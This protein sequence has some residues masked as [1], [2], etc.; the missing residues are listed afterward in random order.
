MMR[1]LDAMRLES[2]TTLRLFLSDREAERAELVQDGSAHPGVIGDLLH[3]LGDSLHEDADQ[4]ITAAVAASDLAEERLR[5]SAPTAP[6]AF[7]P[8]E[9]AAEPAAVEEKTSA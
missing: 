9:P 8:P 6:V 2:F 1:M 3:R 5:E 4:H 7:T